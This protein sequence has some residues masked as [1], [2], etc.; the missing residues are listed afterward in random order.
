MKRSLASSLPL[1]AALLVSAVLNGAPTPP[2]DQAQFDALARQAETC[3]GGYGVWS[4][5]HEAYYMELVPE[6]KYRQMKADYLKCL[7]GMHKLRPEDPGVCVTYAS[8]LVYLGQNDLAIKVLGPAGKLPNLNALQQANILVWLAEAALNKGDKAGAIQ[9]LEDL[10]GRNLNTQSRGGPDPA[11]LAKE[12]LA[13]LKGIDLDAQKLPIETGARAFPEP[14]DAKYT[15]SFAPLKSVRFALGKGIKPDDARVKLLTAKLARFGIK[16]ENNAPFTI[17]INEGAIKA[18]E[19]EEGYALQVSKAGAILQGRDKVGTTWAAVSFIQLVDQAKKSVRIC[20]INDW[21]ETPQR[22]H[23]ESNHAALEPALFN[24]SS[25]VMN[26]SALTYSYGPTPLRMLTL[27]EPSRICAEFGI[28]FYVGDRSLS[29]YP[30]Y[31]LSSDRT[32]QLNLDYFTK[33]AEAGGHGLF[34]YDDSRYPLHPQDVKLNKNGAGQDAKFLTRLFREIRKK[35]PDFRLIFCPP[36]YWGPYYSS[37]FKNYEKNN[38][39]SWK[40]Y[41]RSI[42]EELDPAIDVFWTGE[43]MVAYDMEKR[44]TDWAKAEFGRPPFIWQNR[45]LPHA[46]HYGAMVDAIPWNLMQYEGFGDDVSGFV[47]NQSSPSCAVVFGAMGAALWN[48]KAFDPRETTRRVT[49]MFFGKGIFEILQPGSEAFFFMDSFTREGQFTPYM[50]REKDKFEQA[51]KTARDAYDKAMKLNPN[52]M[53]IYGGGGYGYARTLGIMEGLLKQARAAKPD[54]F[55]T[56]YAAKIAA[57]MEL[58]KKD[59]GFN[60]DK[61]DMYKSL[62]DMFGGEIADEMAR[63]PKTPASVWLRGVFLLPR[64]NWLEIPFETA[65]PGRYE[66]ILSGEEEEHKDRPVTWRILLNGKV[67]YEGRTGFKQRERAVSTFELPADKVARNNMIRIECLAQGG[68]PWNGPWIQ[69]DYA[70][71]RKK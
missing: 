20:E 60:P 50:L 47:A 71:L 42:R 69:I 46:Y 3:A 57:G 9:Y 39:E 25:A 21:P 12:A 38:N 19:K 10:A 64:V 35:N 1:G 58:A 31:P 53:A 29:M 2:Q 30:K 40:D 8:Y 62:P 28:C 56:R 54:Y 49:E 6:E 66:L 33:I 7:E 55:Q 70:V 43:R 11:G 26:Q 59:I 4:P 48:R 52:A 45:P 24:K 27:L 14:Q 44:D 5:Q 36:F 63:N 67:V 51:A 23:L 34:L 32:L 61:G 17:S 41:N 37:T 16:A 18:P 15:D 68:T 65:T 13:W 22:G